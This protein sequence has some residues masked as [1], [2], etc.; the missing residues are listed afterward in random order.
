MD[1]EEYERRQREI[2]E[3]AASE[4]ADYFDPDSPVIWKR[5]IIGPVPRWRRVLWWFFPPSHQKMRRIMRRQSDQMWRDATANLTG[6]RIP[7]GRDVARVV[8]LSLA[9]PVALSLIGSI[10]YGYKN[11]PYRFVLYWAG[12]CTIGTI[13]FYRRSFNAAFGDAPYSFASKLINV[14]A[15]VVTMSL[16]FLAINSAVYF[17][18]RSIS[19]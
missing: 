12:A 11:D 10:Y 3:H 17:F 2:A 4:G 13:W 7:T 9:L 1:R 18:I 5:Y 16:C 6:S 14:I 15:I 19:N 8:S